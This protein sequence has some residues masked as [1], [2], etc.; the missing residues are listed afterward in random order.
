MALSRRFASFTYPFDQRTTRRG[1][2]VSCSST[3]KGTCL[4]GEEREGGWGIGDLF[5]EA[6][7]IEKKYRGKTVKSGCRVILTRD[8]DLN[9][10]LLPFF[11][12]HLRRRR[13]LLSSL[14]PSLSSH[15]PYPDSFFLLHIK[16]NF[17][18][19]L[20]SFFCL[21]D[22]FSLSPFFSLSKKKRKKNQNLFLSFFLFKRTACTSR[23][24]RPSPRGAR[25]S[26]PVPSPSRGTSRR[27]R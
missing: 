20:H 22:F 25:S 2:R 3:G 12:N 11:P 21:V 26:P 8:L 16:I 15:R 23:T 24:S 18:F 27:G 10:F 1:R 6:R 19:L 14:P 13:P 7:A 4:P 9:F 17:L 5:F